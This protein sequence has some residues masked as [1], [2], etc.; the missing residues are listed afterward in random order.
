VD[1]QGEEFSANVASIARTS[2]KRE[3]AGLVDLKR[4]QLQD[5]WRKLYGSDPPEQISR[6]LLTQAIAHRLQMKVLGGLNF[7]TRRAL[8]V[9]GSKP[10]T[11]TEGL[12]IDTGVVLIRVWHGTTHQVTTLKDGIQYRGRRYH[13]LSEVARAITGTRWSGPR[14]FGLKAGARDRVAG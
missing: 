8:E 4:A 14:F 12:G 10:G 11:R 5:L 6:Q 13:S 1:H 2:L 3:L 9:I 7:S